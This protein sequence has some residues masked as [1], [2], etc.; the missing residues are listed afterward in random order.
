M[1]FDF[2]ILYDF[3]FFPYSTRLIYNILRAL[4]Y[5]LYTHKNFLAG[6]SGL[7]FSI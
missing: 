7:Q 2:I 4:Q 6:V 3:D 5:F 1:L